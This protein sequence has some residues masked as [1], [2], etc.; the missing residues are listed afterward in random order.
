[1]SYSSYARIVCGLVLSTIFGVGCVAPRQAGAEISTRV[2]VLGMIHGAHRSS[3]RWGLEQVEQTIRNYAPDVILCEIPP[4]RWGRIWRDYSTNGLIM[5]DRVKLFPEY[6]DVLLPLK[7]ELG[8]EVEPCAAWTRKMADLRRLRMKMASSDPKYAESWRR[9]QEETAAIEAE[10]EAHPIVEDDPRVIHS[11]LYDTRTKRELGPYDRYL[12]DLIGP[13]G[14]TN[15]NRA[16]YRLIDEAIRRHPGKRLLIMFGAGHKYWFLERLR[17]RSD[18]ELVDVRPYLPN[19]PR[20]SS[21]STKSDLR[22]T[23]AP[24]KKAPSP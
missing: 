22:A 17:E 19:P 12:N 16:H 14:W 7:S 21:P 2:A 13:G 4:D 9:Y 18:I 6:T 20:G 1:M 8:F 23:T 3:R 5:D 24:R 11:E 15:I 10:H